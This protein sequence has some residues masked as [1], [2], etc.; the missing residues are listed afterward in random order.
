M[1]RS[2]LVLATAS[3]LLAAPAVSLDDVLSK[4]RGQVLHF[5]DQFANVHCTE[6]ILQTKLAENGKPIV[7]RQGTFDYLVLMQLNDGE[8]RMEESRVQRG[9]PAKQTD[10]SLLSTSG[11]STLI[12]IFHPHFQASYTFTLAA[13]ADADKARVHFEPVRGKPTPAILQLRNREYPI[14]WEGDAIIDRETG[15]VMRIDAGL[16]EPLSDVGLQKL[17]SSVS[18][19]PVGFRDLPEPAWLPRE[20]VIEAQTAHQHWMNTHTFSAYKEFGVSV[21]TDTATPKEV[22][23]R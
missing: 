2:F 11:F 7:Q 6:T 14:E 21:Q 23:R 10:R 17:A 13:T 3:S 18:Y 12:L 19:T 1:I 5:W 20:A 4:A 8:L 16:A 22:K 9:K 15:A